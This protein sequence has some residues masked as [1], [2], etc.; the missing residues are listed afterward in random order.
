M[1]RQSILD[2]AGEIGVPVR[3]ANI[4][5]YDVIDAQEAFFASTPFVIMPATRFN[6]RPVGDG[7]VGPI[8]ARLLDAF[9][10]TVGVDI[11]AQAKAYGRQ[12]RAG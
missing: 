2:L 6:D 4:E 10:E 7:A 9:S 5:P 8:T 1:T 3:E 11:V 12:L